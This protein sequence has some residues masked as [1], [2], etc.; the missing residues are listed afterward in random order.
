[1]SFSTINNKKYYVRLRASSHNEL[2]QY[3]VDSVICN[4]IILKEK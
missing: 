3:S 4:A 2:M 1:M